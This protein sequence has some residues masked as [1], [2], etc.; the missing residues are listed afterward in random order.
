MEVVREINRT[1]SIDIFIRDTGIG[2]SIN[3]I[4]NIFQQYYRVDNRHTQTQF[5]AGIGLSLVKKLVELHRGTL[6][7]ESK[8]EEGSCFTI[9]IPL[10]EQYYLPYEKAETQ[11]NNPDALLNRAE[12]DL[13]SLEPAILLPSG[14]AK[15]KILLVEDNEELIHFMEDQLTEDYEVFRAANGVEALQIVKNNMPALIVSDVMMDKMNG[16]E[17]CKRIKSQEETRHI[18]VILLTARN[19]SQDHLEGLAT[20]ADEYL[21]KPLNAHQL[22]LRINNLIATY[23]NVRQR[24][25]NKLIGDI[26]HLELTDNHKEFVRKV[27][28]VLEKNITNKDI[29]I[30]LFA[31]ELGVS[32]TLLYERI[33][34]A[35]GESLG[36][37]IKTS[38]LKYAAKLLLEN[39]YNTAE[40]AYQVGFSDPKYFSKCFR[41]QFG[42][43]PKEFLKSK[44]NATV[45][46]D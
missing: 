14:K 28:D 35:T 30:D 22:K 17:L 19:S 45:N 38:R 27:A 39:H 31:Q 21:A 44:I 32:R 34:K 1:D 7:V 37:F 8:E 29:N 33:K 36:I 20:G 23:K 41:K 18:P 40:L 9:H 15:E 13:I 2:I 46:Q 24:Y 43:T 42:M 3:D 16:Y 6:T 4:D 26:E 11:I 25:E 12:P 10:H 5:G